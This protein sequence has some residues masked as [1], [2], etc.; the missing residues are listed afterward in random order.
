HTTSGK[1]RNVTSLAG[2]L[3]H[4]LIKLAI[5]LKGMRRMGMARFTTSTPPMAAAWNINPVG[6]LRLHRITAAS[7]VV[8]I[9]GVACGASKIQPFGIHMHI[10]RMI[11]G[12]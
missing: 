6:V 9:G 2:H 1:S 4:V 5:K 8:L 10:K 12:N 3:F 11:W 7:G